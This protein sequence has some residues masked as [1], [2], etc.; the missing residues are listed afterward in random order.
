LQNAGMRHL[1]FMTK[2]AAIREISKECDLTFFLNGNNPDAAYGYKVQGDALYVNERYYTP[3]RH[4]SD[5]GLAG[6]MES[7]V[8]LYGN[9][10]L[11]M[12]KDEILKYADTGLKST[13]SS[14]K[15]FYLYLP[16]MIPEVTKGSV[17]C[18]MSD[19]GKLESLWLNFDA[20]DCVSQPETV[21]DALVHMYSV[22]YGETEP[23]TWYD[24]ETVSYDWE[25]GNL[26][27]RIVD[28]NDGEYSVI[29]DMG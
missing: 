2:C 1:Q 28:W 15:D 24:N 19:A 27:I 9:L 10:F 26:R 18:D 22:T 4:V 17:F 11:G 25:L 29:Y 14:G 5:A 7:G 6:Y 3:N 12:T 21:R 13:D 16:P 23:R 20:G 8:R